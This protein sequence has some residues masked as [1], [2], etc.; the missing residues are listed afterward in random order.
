MFK[1]LVLSLGCVAKSVVDLEVPE[2]RIHAEEMLAK[3][4]GKFWTTP[5][6]DHDTP[7]FVRKSVPVHYC[8]AARPS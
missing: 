8:L 4:M 5:T 3:S 1:T 6:F 7:T 2:G